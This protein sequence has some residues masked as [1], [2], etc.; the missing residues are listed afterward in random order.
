MGQ[1]RDRWYPS[2]PLQQ[3]DLDHRLELKL[4]DLYSF[5]NHIDNFKEMITYFKDKKTN[6]KR[7]KENKKTISTILKSFDTFVIKATTS[8]SFSL[9]LQKSN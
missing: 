4:N 1:K 5:N 3:D 8:S 2:A 7:I 9:M 6:P